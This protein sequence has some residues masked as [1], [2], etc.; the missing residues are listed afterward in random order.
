MNRKILIGSIVAASLL[1]LVSFS[2]IVSAQSTKS[3][4]MNF[5]NNFLRIK[6]NKKTDG[7]I[8]GIITIFGGILL[9]F[10][11]WLYVGLATSN[12]VAINIIKKI[13]TASINLIDLI[14]GLIFGII[15]L[16]FALFGYETHFSDIM[17]YWG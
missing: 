10:L 3:Q 4:N 5:V 13:I 2:S 6:I 16:L 11:I 7:I 9:A 15:I 8:G 1:V 14:P 12:D 17:K